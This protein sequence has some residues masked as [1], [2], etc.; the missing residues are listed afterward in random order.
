MDSWAQRIRHAAMGNGVGAE[1][2]RAGVEPGTLAC[3]TLRR[4]ASQT[5]PWWRVPRFECKRSEMRVYRASQY[6]PDN[7]DKVYIPIP[8]APGQVKRR[9]R[10]VKVCGRKSVS[11]R[12]G[13]SQR[14]P[15]AKDGAIND[16]IKKPRVEN[17]NATRRLGI[18]FSR[19]G[20]KKKVGEP[21]RHSPLKSQKM[22]P[23][24]T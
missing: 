4:G 14:G 10:P 2:G 5:I 8:L 6:S 9:M 16:K 21:L 18:A 19:T 3:R 20:K 24:T 15:L 23:M 17:A 22:V 13:K 12:A 7:S 1:M 11:G